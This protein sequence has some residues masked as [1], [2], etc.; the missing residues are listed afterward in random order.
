MSSIKGHIGY[1]RKTLRLACTRNVV[2]IQRPLVRDCGSCASSSLAGRSGGS[3][4]FGTRCRFSLSP[5]P[6]PL[7]AATPLAPVSA[8]GSHCTEAE[9]FTPNQSPSASI[10]KNTP[11]RVFPSRRSVAAAAGDESSRR[12]RDNGGGGGKK[13]VS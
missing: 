11:R 3:L 6:P 13:K 10:P 9:R 1:T 8:R 7:P 4:I 12:E 5:S 2:L